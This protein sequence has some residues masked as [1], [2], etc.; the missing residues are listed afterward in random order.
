M[1]TTFYQLGLGVLA[2]YEQL[3]P[4]AT[5]TAQ[6]DTDTGRTAYSCSGARHTCG[7]V[8]AGP[9]GEMP[10]DGAHNQTRAGERLP[11]AGNALHDH[12]H[13]RG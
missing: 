11:A 12:R 7:R 6:E 5:Q 2:L 1:H 9:S 10:G 4:S 3:A 8:A 13:D